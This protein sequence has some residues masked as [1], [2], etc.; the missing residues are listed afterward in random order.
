MVGDEITAEFSG[1][2]FNKR[3]SMT[4]DA[5]YRF[6]DTSLRLKYLYIST[7]TYEAWYIGKYNADRATFIASAPLLDAGIEFHLQWVDLY[8][9][10]CTRP[11]G[12]QVDIGMIATY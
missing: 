10:G 12:A 3:I 6:S 5:V 2:V 11:T 4:T 7:I 1:D 9:L 8:N